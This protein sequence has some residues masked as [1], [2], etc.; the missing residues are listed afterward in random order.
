MSSFEIPIS[1]LTNDPPITLA[2]GDYLL[3]IADR[4]MCQVRYGLAEGFPAI[5]WGS[6]RLDDAG[7]TLT[8]RRPGRMDDE[9]VRHWICVDRVTFSDGAHPGSFSGH[10]DPWPLQAAGHGSSLTRVASDRYGDDPN[11]WLAAFPSPGA[12]KR[13]A[14]R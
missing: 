5:E 14:D 3:L 4:P 10:V 9:G 7:G 12:A 8:L 11:N 6:A 1:N 2:P 13:R